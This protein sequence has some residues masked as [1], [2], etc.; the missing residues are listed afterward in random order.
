MLE[1]SLNCIIRKL[2][3]GI[4][5]VLFGG[6][7]IEGGDS[8]GCGD[9]TDGF[10]CCWLH[11]APSPPLREYGGSSS[12]FPEIRSVTLPQQAGEA[13]RL[14]PGEGALR[15]VNNSELCTHLL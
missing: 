6:E 15:G 9:L 3:S 10:Y 5:H 11:G 2:I 12:Y 8:K 14:S 7:K 1:W 13:G 4:E